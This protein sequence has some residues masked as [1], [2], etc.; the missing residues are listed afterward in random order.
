MRKILII[1]DNS[2]VRAAM[3]RILEPAGYETVTAG[4][5]NEGLIRMRQE[6]PDLI[7]GGG[8]HA[9]MDFLDAARKLGA[10]DVLEKPFEPDELVDRVSRCIMAV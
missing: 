10:I 7:S 4:D 9:N 6:D 2:A 8:R 5:G 1:D 3:P